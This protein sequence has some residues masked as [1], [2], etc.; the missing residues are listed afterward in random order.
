MGGKTKRGESLPPNS[1][2]MKIAQ[3]HPSRWSKALIAM[4]SNRF[5]TNLEPLFNVNKEETS[6]NMWREWRPS[7]YQCT[8]YSRGY[9]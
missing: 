6:T 3:E 8:T 1:F 2:L 9:W 7:Y 5:F 4:L